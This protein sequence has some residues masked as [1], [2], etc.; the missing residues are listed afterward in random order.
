LEGQGS[1]IFETW[2]S[3]EQGGRALA[4][5]LFGEANPSGHLPISWEAKI[6]DNP[7]YSNYYPAAGTNQIAYREGIFVGYRGYEHTNTQPLFPFGYG[8]SYTTF[9]YNNLSTAPAADGHVQVSFDVTNTGNRA[10][11]AVAQLYVG[12]AKPTVD[13]PT[14]ELKGFQ[15]VMLEPKETKHVIID[16]NPRSFAFF[17]VRSAVW[18]A[19]A[20]SYNLLLGD[21][22]AN[23]Q[24]QATVQLQKTITIP[25]SD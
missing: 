10:G 23:I 11:A 17:D 3:G 22:V 25:V 7:S 18:R 5:L 6:T 13:R 21:S 24:Q 14:K 1:A 19:N 16:L 20:G 9:T 15:R 8:L 12:E 4:Q 2:Y